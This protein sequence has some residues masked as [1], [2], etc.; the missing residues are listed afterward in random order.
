MYQAPDASR[1]YQELQNRTLAASER[2][3]AIEQKRTALAALRTQVTGVVDAVQ[4]G[5]KTLGAARM[6]FSEKKRAVEEKVSAKQNQNNAQQERLAHA[7]QQEEMLKQQIASTSAAI[8]AARAA[9]EQRQRESNALAEAEERLTKVKLQLEDD[10]NTLFQIGQ[11]VERHE[12]ATLKRHN[13]LAESLPAFPL[14]QVSTPGSAGGLEA[15]ATESLILID[16]SRM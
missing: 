12:A 10:G 8:N 4:R 14:A 13:Q 16:D 3:R 11:R 6:E 2:E 15:T 7:V 9:I 1:V 5:K